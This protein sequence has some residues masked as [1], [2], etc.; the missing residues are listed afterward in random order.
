[1]NDYINKLKE[2][3]AEYEAKSGLPNTDTVLELLWET[4]F[5]TN[6]VDDGLIR[7]RRAALDP[8][9]DKLSLPD[10]DSLTGLIADLVT[11]YQRAAFLEGIHIGFHLNEA[12][13]GKSAPQN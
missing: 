11:A 7:R 3:L 1:M 10:S 8:V 4:Y 13:Q 12:L 5:E 9:F 6:P 2:D